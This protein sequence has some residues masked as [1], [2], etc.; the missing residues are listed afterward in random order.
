MNNENKKKQLL[1]NIV[2]EK[3]RPSND[4]VRYIVRAAPGY[5]K[6]FDEVESA[7]KDIEKSKQLA[8]AYL[9]RNR[10]D[11]GNVFLFVNK[12]DKIAFKGQPN[13]D[14]DFKESYF[15][16]K[17]NISCNNSLHKISIIQNQKEKTVKLT[18]EE[19]KE[20]LLVGDDQFSRDMA[21]KKEHLDHFVG[22]TR[23]QL[24]KK[25]I[26]VNLKYS[27]AGI[28]YTRD[29][30]KFTKDIYNEH[31]KDTSRN[32][33]SQISRILVR[34]KKGM[35]FVSKVDAK[36]TGL[37]KVPLHI[38]KRICEEKCNYNLNSGI[39]NPKRKKDLIK[40]INK[41]L[42]NLISHKDKY[43]ERKI[44]E[45]FGNI[46]LTPL[47]KLS[48]KN[49]NKTV[50][51]LYNFLKETPKSINKDTK[52]DQN[53]TITQRR[54][55]LA[56]LVKGFKFLNSN[57][58]NTK[59]VI[60]YISKCIFPIRVKET[61]T[62]KFKPSLEDLI[63]PHLN[64]MLGTGT[65]ETEVNYN[66]VNEIKRN[67]TDK[68]ESKYENLYDN[69]EKR[70]CD[71][72]GFIVL[73]PRE[74]DMRK[75][76]K[77]ICSH[78]GSKVY[79]SYVTNK[80]FDVES[81]KKGIKNKRNMIIEIKDYTVKTKLN[82]FSSINVKMFYGGIKGKNMKPEYYLTSYIDYTQPTL[83]E[84][85]IMTE[86]MYKNS[87]EGD[88]SHN[89]MRFLQSLAIDTRRYN[90]RNHINEIKRYNNIKKRYLYVQ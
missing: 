46:E 31:K 4:I 22:L 42:N 82:N 68:L 87:K 79:D 71:K 35:R 23:E 27:F 7:K 53:L 72:F 33:D 83:I 73:C 85:Q 70:I 19:R 37:D 40:N 1:E 12:L 84:F 2:S 24:N 58:K 54:E 57:K 74:S 11:L 59:D 47:K 75:M 51:E 90:N 80:N 16:F 55:D 6:I 41:Y 44:L 36:E 89:T 60:K 28:H 32:T 66:F 45:K 38:Y 86:K 25:G 65:K 29:Y 10:F 39:L 81:L 52:E 26:N 9:K 78:F 21:L 34:Q 13:C 77:K 64:I 49:L 15:T 48:K 50:K 63:Y 5:Q 17:Y 3:S 62:K 14:K 43:Y 67:K 56:N 30:K 8:A 61:S 18:E 20:I 88:A 76:L 69:S